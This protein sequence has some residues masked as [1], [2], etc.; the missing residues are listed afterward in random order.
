MKLRRRENDISY[1]AVKSLKRD[2]AERI[3]GRLLKDRGL[4]VTNDGMSELVR[5]SDCHPFNIY[6]MIEEIAEHG[7]PAFLANPSDFIDWKHRQSSEYLTKIQFG[8]QDALILGLL[9]QLPELDFT[10]I[11]AA[12]GLDAA[13]TSENLRRLGDL[14]IVESSGDAFSISPA[15]QVAVERDRRF[16]LDRDV[17]QAA[18]KSLAKSLAIRLE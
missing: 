5:L 3:I 17:Q 1:L 12:L 15:L 6:R 10:A 11:V 7:T 18:M 16:R 8:E 9:K 2:S 14:H 13:E 4:G